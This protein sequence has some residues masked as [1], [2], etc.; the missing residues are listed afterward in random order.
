MKNKAYAWCIYPGYSHLRRMGPPE[1]KIRLRQH[2]PE[3]RAFYADD[4]W[5]LEIKLEDY[6]RL[7]VC[8]IH[9]RKDYDLKQHSKFSK[10]DL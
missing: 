4:A 5:D 6:G 3:E 1:E 9:N 7:E 2:F 8:G 10:I